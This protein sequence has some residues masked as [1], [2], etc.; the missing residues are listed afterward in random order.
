MTI[1][2]YQDDPNY[3]HS[4]ITC[5]ACV[6]I[7]IDVYAIDNSINTQMLKTPN[8]LPV[9]LVDLKMEEIQKLAH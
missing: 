8:D 6:Q 2:S 5:R 1:N 7:L 3:K 9:Q 4:C